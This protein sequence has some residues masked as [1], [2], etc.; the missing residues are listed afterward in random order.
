MDR[1]QSSN[2]R[3]L[4]VRAKLMCAMVFVALFVASAQ[5]AGTG[6]KKIADG[7]YAYAGQPTGTP[8]NVF[9]ANAGVIIG[10]NCVLVVDTL[11]SAEEARNLVKD[12]KA[13]TDKPIRY[14]VNTHYHLDHALGNSVFKEL[15]AVIIA[16]A[17]CR[18]SLLQSGPGTLK[19]PAGFGLPAD[20]WKNTTVAAPDITFSR[21]YSIDLGNMPVTVMYSGYA[22]HS[23]G[24]SVV[25]IPGRDVVFTGDILFTDFHPFI[26]EGDFDGWNKTID[27]IVGMN[28]GTVVPGHGP[29]ADNRDLEAM[30]AYIAVFDAKARELAAAGVD[31]QTAN[32]E[33]VKVLPPRK[34]GAFLIGFNL[35]SRYG[36]KPSAV[37]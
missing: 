14:V 34:D 13:I 27:M 35:M 1:T 28:I 17:S 3:S 15:G 5:A 29:V 32:A 36:I 22:S 33:M 12:I 6:L 20:F 31:F 21:S 37:R 18:E 9:G 19:N 2:R 11:T 30:K 8:T 24:S 7:V 25:V 4:I 16:Q 26:G 23:K 10:D